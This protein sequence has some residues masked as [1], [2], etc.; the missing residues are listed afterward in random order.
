MSS[1]AVQ[2]LWRLGWHGPFGIH[3]L[4]PSNFWRLVASAVSISSSLRVLMITR[5]AFRYGDLLERNYFVRCAAY[6][7]LGIG[8]H[9]SEFASFTAFFI[10]VTTDCFSWFIILLRR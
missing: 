7:W 1:I 8:A 10:L 9:A 2:I 3:H 6:P 5:G 4:S